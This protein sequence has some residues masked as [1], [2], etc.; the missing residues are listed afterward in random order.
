MLPLTCPRISPP[1]FFAGVDV[2]VRVPALERLRDGGAD[3]SRAARRRGARDRREGR[4]PGPALPFAPEWTCAAVAA[5]VRCL[6]VSFQV[7]FVPVTVAVKLPPALIEAPDSFGTSCLVS[8]LALKLHRRH[9]RPRQRDCRDDGRPRR[10]RRREEL[11]FVCASGDS[12]PIRVS[13]CGS[14]MDSPTRYSPNPAF[15][16]VCSGER[17]RRPAGGERNATQD[18]REPGER[19]PA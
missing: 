9:R 5:P 4:S 7:I 6:K 13:G 12:P 10:W 15:R 1:G 17:S 2:H 14:V 8:R 3:T 16:I 11:S 18:E 19:L